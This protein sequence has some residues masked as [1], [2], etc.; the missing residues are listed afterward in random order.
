MPIREDRTRKTPGCDDTPARSALQ[1][2]EDVGGPRGGASLRR[3]DAR[4][5]DG[6]V[7]SGA[8]QRH[9][10]EGSGTARATAA[11]AAMRATRQSGHVCGDGS[12]GSS[13][14]QPVVVCSAPV[15]SWWPWQ[16]QEPA[17]LVDPGPPPRWSAI[18]WIAGISNHATTAATT[19]TEAVTRRLTARTTTIIVAAP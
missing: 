10:C 17:W 7:G 6:F 16:Q 3:G 5:G 1:Q 14:G 9:S 18:V 12:V 15:P 11:D 8:S 2:A 13:S 19:A 4:A